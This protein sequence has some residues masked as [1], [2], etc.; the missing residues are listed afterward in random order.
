M[1]YNNQVKSNKT[2]LLNLEYMRVHI[3]IL[4]KKQKKTS[5]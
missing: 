3:L 4:K 5:R 2:F 1:W